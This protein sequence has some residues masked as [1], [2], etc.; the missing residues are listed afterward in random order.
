[1]DFVWLYLEMR[2]YVLR[3]QPTQKS[4]PKTTYLDKQKTVQQQIGVVKTENLV[5]QK[6]HHV[7]F[8][9]LLYTI[10][11]GLPKLFMVSWWQI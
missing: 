1:M 4:T 11:G 9:T 5:P 10:I 7:R 2:V 8:E 3:V 6:I